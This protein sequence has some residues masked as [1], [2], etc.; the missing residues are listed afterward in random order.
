M[1]EAS[2]RHFDV[3]SLKARLRYDSRMIRWK[4]PKE[5][6]RSPSVSRMLRSGNLLSFLFHLPNFLRLYWSLFWDKKAPILPKVLLVLAVIYF[7][8][9]LDLVPDFAIPGLGYIDDLVLLV[10]ALKY[11]IKAMPQSLVAEKVD[12]IDRTSGP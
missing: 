1:P 2:E 7:L 12:T 9:P 3:L 5:V 6:R 8:S 4:K 11:F 10:L